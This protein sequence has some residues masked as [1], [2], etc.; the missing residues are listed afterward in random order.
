MRQTLAAL[1]LFSA[2]SAGAE[3][4]VARVYD[5][6]KVIDRVAEVSR[7]DLPRD[8][9]KR[10][11]TEDIDLLR[12]KRKDGTYEYASFERLEAS[13]TEKDFSIQTRPEDSLERVE[14]RGEFVYRMIVS[15]P[16]R[17][18]LVTR[19]KPIFI[20]RVDLEYIPVGSSDTKRTSFPVGGM[21][22]PGG[23]RAFDFPEVAKQAT[24]F[25]FAR[26]TEAGYG[27]VNV[28][29]THAKIF[30]LPES[31]YAG[32]VTTAKA[33]L[34]GVDNGDIPSL[35]AMAGRLQRE[36]A[37]RL[38]T[39]AG[40]VPAPSSRSQSS[41][42]VTAPREPSRSLQSTP[43]VEIYM[44]LQQIEDLVTGTEAERR[45]GVDKLH[46]LL[47]KLRSETARSE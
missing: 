36:L 29:L 31:P 27:N 1:L 9:L 3:V 19:N 5:D 41:I 22:E 47:R 13:R 23:T 45:E 37:P 40:A 20:D 18:M 7:R 44:E 26:G 17:R 2:L 46:Q 39:T 28:I 8:L 43:T 24:I 12:G 30:D 16:S 33:I 34:R 21:L 4:Q 38:G 32:A 42:D 6:A 35:R 15:L 10:I 25:L 14:M 11:V